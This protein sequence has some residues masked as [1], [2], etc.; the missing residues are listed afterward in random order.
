MAQRDEFNRV[1]RREVVPVK[2]DSPV[3]AIG[4]SAG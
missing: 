4:L 1:A 3:M 2:A